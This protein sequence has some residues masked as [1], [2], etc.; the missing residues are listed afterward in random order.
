MH[1]AIAASRRG[2][3]VGR[4]LV[5]VVQG[6]WRDRQWM[7]R[8]TGRCCARGPEHE[9]VYSAAAVLA[10]LAS[11]A[12]SREAAL[13]ALASA[14][15]A[16]GP[17]SAVAGGEAIARESAQ[18][19]EE[20]DEYRLCEG[21]PPPL[22]AIAAEGLGHLGSAAPRVAAGALVWALGEYTARVPKIRTLADFD[23]A[24]VVMA[25]A[26]ALALLASQGGL[27][28][29]PEH[30]EGVA[31][32]LVQVALVLAAPELTSELRGQPKDVRRYALAEVLEALSWAGGAAGRALALRLARSGP[33]HLPGAGEEQT[34]AEVDGASLRRHLRVRVCSHT[35]VGTPY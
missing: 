35:A 27:G 1:G 4:L 5:E 32:A 30:E 9:L 14:L 10:R 11:Q 20:F 21:G 7:Q 33:S 34:P 2:A 28:R 15:R 23:D 24:R 19:R 3:D 18:C 31:E 25:A 26:R 8:N 13:R 6:R 22:Q 16:G 17:S 29:E 12:P